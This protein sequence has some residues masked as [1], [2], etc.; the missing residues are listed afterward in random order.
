MDA[1]LDDMAYLRSPI[2]R[3]YPAIEKIKQLGWSPSISLHDGFERT[4]NS[5]R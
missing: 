5:F 4:V 3:A 2:L 1:K